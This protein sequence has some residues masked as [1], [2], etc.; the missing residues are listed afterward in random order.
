MKL[1]DAINKINNENM[2]IFLNDLKI[3]YNDI[4]SQDWEIR[5]KNIFNQN[6]DITMTITLGGNCQECSGEVNK[7]W[8]TIKNLLSLITN[9][10]ISDRWNDFK[11]ESL[12]EYSQ[13]E[14][15]QIKDTVCEIVLSGGI[16]QSSGY[17]KQCEIDDVDCDYDSDED[18][19]NQIEKCLNI[20]LPHVTNDNFENKDIC[21]ED[22]KY[23]TYDYVE[24]C[25]TEDF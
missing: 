22:C 24:E 11:I 21:D 13:K 5:E 7:E 20:L 14:I 16:N 12:I 19:K 17:G 2:V 15:K 4:E 9:K 8:Y 6:T 23:Y 25:L 10:D 1:T 18:L 3:Q